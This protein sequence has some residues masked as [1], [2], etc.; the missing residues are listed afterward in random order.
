MERIERCERGIT[1]TVLMRVR[2]WLAARIY[3]ARR[4]RKSH[5]PSSR[6]FAPA[7][8]AAALLVV[9]MMGCRQESDSTT[10]PTPAKSVSLVEDLASARKVF[11]TKLRVRGPAPQHYK[12][13]KPPTDV[14]LVEFTSGDL[15]LKG[16]LS[17]EV[18][19]G[20]KRPAIVYLHG[21][22]AFDRMDWE[23]AE[24]FAKA[25]FVL[26]MPMVRGEN[27]NPGTYESFLG[28]VDDERAAGR[29]VSSL[30]NVDGGNVFVTGHSVEGC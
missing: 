14:K 4:R 26:F 1:G 8:R 28:E 10:R 30:P 3:P 23:D 6:I 27:G 21:G 16:W 18:A 5:E 11:V 2:W 13:D 29:F 25:G 7:A 9:G 15:K 20:K 17:A 22:W 12:N 19:E 24:P